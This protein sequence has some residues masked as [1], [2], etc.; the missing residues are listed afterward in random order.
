MYILKENDKEVQR[1]D[2]L[3]PLKK[4]VE[5][6][7]LKKGIKFSIEHEKEKKEKKK[8]EE[9]DYSR[10][11]RLKRQKKEKAE[12]VVKALEK[13]KKSPPK[14]AKPKE[15]KKRNKPMIRPSIMKKEFEQ[16]DEV[17]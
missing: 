3:K 7:R 4:L 11:Q 1:D 15:V 17:R 16:F 10:L 8:A 6:R 2:T 13:S 5:A 12:K 14:K 9:D